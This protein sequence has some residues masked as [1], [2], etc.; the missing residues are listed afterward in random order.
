M[1]PVG[2]RHGRGSRHSL[3]HPHAEPA[4]GVG[5]VQACLLQGG[6]EAHSWI[7]VPLS[8]RTRKLWLLQLSLNFSRPVLSL[9]GWWQ[10]LRRRSSA[11]LTCVHLTSSLVLRVRCASA[12]AVGCGYHVWP[13]SPH[14]PGITEF[15]SPS[16]CG[17]VVRLC[18]P[19]SGDL[20][21]LC[22]PHYLLA[23][24]P[25]Q[26]AFPGALISSVVKGGFHQTCGLRLLPGA[27]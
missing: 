9:R 25:E 19:E 5:W 11:W 27:Q 22:C 26:D 3:V 16:V 12:G 10:R 23:D 21:S 6:A 1:T 4:V 7:L 20:N 15:V 17:E 18:G 13:R 24:A 14:L 2:P 8:L